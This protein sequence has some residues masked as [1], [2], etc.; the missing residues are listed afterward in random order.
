LE[1]FVSVT[2][3]AGRRQARLA[4]PMLAVLAGACQTGLDPSE[5]QLIEAR[6]V[7]AD[8]AVASYTMVVTRSG[9]QGS[10]VVVRVTV[11]QGQV[12]DRRFVDTGDPVP[13]ADHAK[14]PNVE[15][16]FD[17]VQDAFDRAD[18]VSV[19]FDSVYG[20]PI[21]IVIDYVRSSLNDDVTMAITGFA[22]AA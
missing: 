5:N 20:F 11:T 17:L 9:L 14:F 19:S 3:I 2:A 1:V 16:L 6:R 7:W 15:G 10:P 18:G 4:W 22:P 13:A 12:T 21:S 8:S